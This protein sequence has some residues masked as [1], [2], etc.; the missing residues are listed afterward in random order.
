ME[1]TKGPKTIGERENP[2]T[3]RA[4]PSKAT[5]C[6]IWNSSL[7]WAMEDA[8][9]LDEKVRERTPMKMTVD[10]KEKFF[11][12]SRVVKNCFWLV[13]V[14]DSNRKLTRCHQNFFSERPLERIIDYWTWGKSW[15]LF[16]MRRSLSLFLD[17][18]VRS[19]NC[20]LVCHIQKSKESLDWKERCQSKTS[21]VSVEGKSGV[22][23]RQEARS[24]CVMQSIFSYSPC[25]VRARKRFQTLIEVA[26]NRVLLIWNLFACFCIYWHADENLSFT[27]SLCSA[28]SHPLF[29]PF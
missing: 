15:S 1:K 23:R 24:L 25:H 8:Y 17:V 2:R 10:R 28:L 6:E 19:C 20:D 14:S 4:I 16:C 3:K 7:I 9:A 5:S 26:W 12:K 22:S 29:S 18:L 27:S 11:R 21:I 13:Q